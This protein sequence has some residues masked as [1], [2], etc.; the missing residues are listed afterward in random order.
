[1]SSVSPSA[2]R[3]TGNSPNWGDIALA[4]KRSQST[5][6]TTTDGTTSP[7]QLYAQ[8]TSFAPVTFEDT[9]QV[10]LNTDLKGIDSQENIR[11]KL[12]AFCKNTNIFINFEKL[13]SDALSWKDIPLCI[14]IINI[15]NSFAIQSKNML[16][17]TEAWNLFLKLFILCDGKEAEAL[18]TLEKIFNELD[19]HQLIPTAKIYEET[20][21][22]F[23]END[24][25]DIA[26]AVFLHSLIKKV[27]DL[28]PN[29][30]KTANLPQREIDC[31]GLTVAM[32][33]VLVKWCLQTYTSSPKFIVKLGVLGDP[34]TQYKENAIIET[35][36]DRLLEFSS[37]YLIEPFR[38]TEQNYSSLIEFTRN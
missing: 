38:L 25:V 10:Y 6:A 36:K 12:C 16:G 1:M 7:T 9:Q 23:F 37:K 3:L 33:C 11:D 20:I 18:S 27:F 26:Y 17:Q 35:K 21:F 32:T 4:R 30:I 19:K 22:H 34:R 14:D 24:Q 2:G 29:V 5:S 13:F 31:N 28:S 15:K 8:T